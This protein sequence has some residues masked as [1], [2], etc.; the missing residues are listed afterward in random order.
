MKVPSRIRCSA[1]RREVTVEGVPNSRDRRVCG[2]Q[3]ES[4]S[5]SGSPESAIT[6]E[7]GRTKDSRSLGFEG[8]LSA[9]RMLR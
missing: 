9:A 2:D 8:C 5:R 7:G 6:E 1:S 4:H 3:P